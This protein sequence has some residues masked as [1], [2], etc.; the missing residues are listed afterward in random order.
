MTAVDVLMIAAAN[1]AIE[2]I[3]ALTARSAESLYRDQPINAVADFLS[4]T[5][6]KFE[7]QLANPL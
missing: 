6:E 2:E 4:E 1:A 5:L 3:R 7:A